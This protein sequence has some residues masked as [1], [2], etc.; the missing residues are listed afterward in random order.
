MN[1]GVVWRRGALEKVAAFGDESIFDCID[2]SI[3]FLAE[4]PS[5]VS[6]RYPHREF[7]GVQSFDFR[8]LG[9]SGYVAIRA[10]FNYTADEKNIRIVDVAVLPE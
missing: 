8:C 5:G 2:V 6:H 7:P 1:Y 4:D 3:R 9:K 10:R